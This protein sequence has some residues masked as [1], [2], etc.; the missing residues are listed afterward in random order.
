[1]AK[2]K[3]GSFLTDIRNKVGGHVFSFYRGSNVVRKG[4]SQNASPSIR[5][6]Q[7][8]MVTQVNSQQWRRLT[9][10]QRNA[11]NAAVSEWSK[12]DVF[13][14]VHN[15]SGFLLYMRLN[16]F[17]Q[18][19]LATPLLLPPLPSIVPA[20]V[21]ISAAAAI[22]AATLTWTQNPAVAGG[23]I[24]YLV[25]RTNIFSAGVNSVK[26]KYVL[27][28]SITPGNPINVTYATIT[29][30]QPTPVVGCVIFF[31]IETYNGATGQK[32]T[33]RYLTTKFTA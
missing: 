3:L 1:M 23:G 17:C 33:T 7:N 21:S 2:I 6:Q 25:Y 32:G 14:N 11:W 10:A 30:G 31:K 28:T 29:S 12:T 18:R 20:F 22:G 9:V 5:R 4:V 15:Q 26:Q 16:Y 13:G 27:V 24:Y 8:R 19:I